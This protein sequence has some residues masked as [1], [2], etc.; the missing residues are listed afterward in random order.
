[1]LAL[2]PVP[3]SD[4]QPGHIGSG[5]FPG[6]RTNPSGRYTLSADGRQIAAGTAIGGAVVAPLP[7][8]PS[9]LGTR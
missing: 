6:A 8:A 9:L 3:F 2:E 1:M 5:L 4:S 7:A